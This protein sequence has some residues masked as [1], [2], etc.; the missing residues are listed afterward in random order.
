MLRKTPIG[1]NPSNQLNTS[2]TS[3]SKTSKLSLTD[4]DIKLDPSDCT[5]SIEFLLSSIVLTMDLKSNQALALLSNSSTLLIHVIVK[6]LKGNFEPIINWYKELFIHCKVLV[7]IFS[8]EA[9]GV[10]AIFHVLDIIKAGLYSKSVEVANWSLR[11][12][13]KIASQMNE[14]GISGVAWDWFINENGCLHIILHSIE[15]HKELLSENIVSVLCQFGM[16]NLK[17]LFTHNMKLAIEDHIGYTKLITRL[18]EPLAKYKTI[19]DELINQGII[20]FWLDYGCRKVDV[21][22]NI[23]ERITALSLLV[24]IWLHFSVG[25]EDERKDLIIR[26]LQRACRDKSIEVQVLAI[27]LLFK[28]LENFALEHNPY[29]LFMYKSLTFALVENHQRVELRE[30]IL[31]NF[32]I[33]FEDCNTIPVNILLDPFIKQLRASNSSIFTFNLF[34]FTFFTS[35]AEHPKLQIKNALQILD[36]LAK[37]YISSHLL[38]YCAIKPFIMIVRRFKKQISLCSY[39]ENLIKVIKSIKVVCIKCI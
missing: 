35:V 6:G 12:L 7:R 30:L 11:L 23:G 27:S 18:I 8:V 34:D 4:S 39:M 10:T 32:I 15:N 5:T 19:H 22:T 2:T 26:L 21:N 24:E 1:S 36:L 33:I 9:E 37:L 28:L 3:H 16:H 20:T 38:S 13:G 29:A 14:Y 25:V 17:E 31:E